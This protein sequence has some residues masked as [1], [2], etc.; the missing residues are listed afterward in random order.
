MRM[1]Y[2][3]LDKKGHIAVVTMRRAP[4]NAVNHQFYREIIEMFDNIGTDKDIRVAALCSEFEK[5]WCA[6]NDVNDFVGMTP[7]NGH[8]RHRSVYNAFMAIYECAVPTIAA[9]DGYAIGNG[10]AFASVCDIIIATDRAV[11]SAPEINFGVM[12]A[13]LLL[14]RLVPEKVVREMVFT[15]RH[16]KAVELERY[17]CLRC[18]P[19]GALMNEVMETAKLIA[20]KCPPTVRLLKESLNCVESMDFKSGLYVEMGYTRKASSFEDSK[21][22]KKAFLEKRE[23]VFKNC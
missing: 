19:P 5:Y 6:G 14:N 15:G 7:E 10:M 2:L 3:T 13:G 22:A 8:I 9:I 11:I 17:G 12:G 21:E 20:S 4:V 1:E 18:V 23:P 16:V